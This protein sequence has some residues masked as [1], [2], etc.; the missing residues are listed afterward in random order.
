[1][2]RFQ[3]KRFFAYLPKTSTKNMCIHSKVYIAC[4]I[5]SRMIDMLEQNT[6]GVIEVEFVHELKNN[7]SFAKNRFGRRKSD[8]DYFYL[9]LYLS[10][11]NSKNKRKK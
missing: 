7:G 4:N 3:T 8:E 9:Y 5:R 1:M 11:K 10:C 6:P 2:G